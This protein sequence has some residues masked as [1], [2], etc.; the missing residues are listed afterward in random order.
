MTET[1]S[2][3]DMLD[4]DG[5]DYGEDV[6]WAAVRDMLKVNSGQGCDV[7]NDQARKCVMCA[8]SLFCALTLLGASLYC[9][10]MTHHRSCC[11]VTT[12][13]TC[14]TLPRRALSKTVEGSLPQ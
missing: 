13:S 9:R 10:S 14:P 2:L 6:A 3:Q 8:P 4:E 12:R 5:R 11:A 1:R 7:A